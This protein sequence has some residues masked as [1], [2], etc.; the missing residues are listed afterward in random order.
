MQ[1]EPII[2]T[3]FIELIQAESTNNYAM[4]HIQEGMAQS[5]SV[6]FTANQTKGK[7]QRG[8]VWNSENGKNLAYSAI[9]KPDELFN[10]NKSFILSAT[11]AIACCNCVN[12][13][14]AN[15]AL[16]KW[17]NDIYWNDR[18]AAGILIENI[19]VGES[20]KWAVIGIGINVNQ[21]EFKYLPNP[22]SLK[23]ITGKEFDIAT[24]ATRLTNC[25]NDSF[26]Y[27]KQFGEESV[28]EQYNILLYKKGE[29]VK[30]KKET[31]TFNA[32]VL[33]AD[34]YGRLHISESVD[35]ELEFGS[36]SWVI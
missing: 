22:V 10:I 26:N 14:V 23:Q 5:G 35:T 32:R 21:T 11:V 33:Q 8:K 34:S 6:W 24:L 29:L 30:F 16:I 28:I 25:L 17:P 4:Q 12:E 36:V 7:G 20:W 27:L 18:K 19:I 1:V 3:P 13:L 15:D 31:R 2:G 9:F